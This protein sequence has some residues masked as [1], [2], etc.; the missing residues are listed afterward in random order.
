MIAVTARARL[1]AAEDGPA[2]PVWRA[3]VLLVV[4]AAGWG[5]SHVLNLHGIAGAQGFLYGVTALL[6]LGLYGSTTQISLAEA[7][8]STRIIVLAVTVGVAVK[9]ALITAVMYAA[10]HE[11]VYL[12][13]GVVVAQIDPLSVIA[14]Q[15]N[16]KLSERAKTILY[17]WSSFDDPVTTLLTIYV[18]TLAL[19]L[20]GTKRGLVGADLGSFALQLLINL[21]FAA[22]A[23]IA[24][25]AL[26]R[27]AGIPVLSPGSTLT[28]AQNL[29]AIAVLSTFTAVAVWQFLMLGIAIAGLFFR[30]YFGPWL[31]RANLAALLVASIA[32]GVLL[33]NG[34][35]WLPGLLLGAATF[36]AQM[37]VALFL[38]RKMSLS[39]RGYL[40]LSQQN[41][42]T[43]IVLALL[44]EHSFK[45][46]VAVVAPA[47]L[48]INTLHVCSTYTFTWL[49]KE[50]TKMALQ[51]LGSEKVESKAF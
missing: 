35:S 25:W 38:T 22:M 49:L 5:L 6:A 51:V 45:G 37:V 16:S 24:W 18:A 26:T 12:V 42:V 44:L 23:I 39:D 14:L 17:S 7:R 10:Y 46:A 1:R 48:V 13:L 21:A 34:V 47:I 20:L 4:T 33:V 43:A 36:V 29:V 28:S 41:G 27:P 40:A 19:N 50:R 8:V 15:R 11:P 31:D 3:L 32:L 2:A 30:P 9:A